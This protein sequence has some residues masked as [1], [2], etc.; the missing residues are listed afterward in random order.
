M[1]SLIWEQQSRTLFCAAVRLLIRPI[2][3]ANVPLRR[4]PLSTKAAQE[5]AR[6][7]EREGIISRSMRARAPS[8]SLPLRGTS[9]VQN[10]EIIFLRSKTGERE[11]EGCGLRGCGRSR[12]GA[13]RKFSLPPSTPKCRSKSLPPR[14]SQEKAAFTSRH[15]IVNQLDSLANVLYCEAFRN[16]W[17][18]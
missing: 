8:S 18:D 17:T 3:S 2:N 10:C 16:L 11:S 14:A 1:G 7:R 6:E 12:I 13:R 9:S 15:R 5:G 4:R